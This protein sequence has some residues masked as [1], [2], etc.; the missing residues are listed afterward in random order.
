MSFK[1]YPIN[2][3]N[4]L[5]NYIW[6]LVNQTDRTTVAI[7]PTQ[8]DLV[9]DF[10]QQHQLTL[11]HIWITHKHHDHIGGLP[12]LRQ[13]TTAQIYAPEAEQGNIGHIDH[14]LKDGD[15]FKFSSLDVDVIATP[16][17]T[18]GHICFFI[19]ALD[20]VFS[21]DTLF[22][23]GCGRLFEGTYAQMY[24]SLNRLA[25]LPERTQVYCTH[26][27]T[28]SNA[29]FALTVESDNVALQQRFEEVKN[30]RAHNQITLPSNIAL[31]LETNPFLRCDSVEEFQRIRQLK[32][33]F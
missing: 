7:D 17:H 15:Q 19:D 10:C 3:G 18:L 31:E 14:L 26:E 32:D 20:A 30:L 33:Q 12:E 13:H 23:M 1:I 16:G 24:H 28:K 11:E 6:M 22:A 25:A 29:K 4:A 9:L 5:Q 2:V 27:Y 21:G 8:A